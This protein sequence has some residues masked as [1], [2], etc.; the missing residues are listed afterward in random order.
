MNRNPRPPLWQ[1]LALLALVAMEMSAYTPW[2][3]AVSPPITA[4]PFARFFLLAAAV[5]LLTHGAYRLARF[6]RLRRNIRQALLVLV[7]ALAARAALSWWIDPRVEQNLLALYR[8]PLRGIGEAP[9]VIPA[10]FWTLLFVIGLWWRGLTLGRER[11]G[12]I[13]VMRSFKIGVLSLALF[14]PAE[15]LMRPEQPAAGLLLFFLFLSS[16]LLALVGSRVSTLARLR[17][18]HRNPFD[19]RWMAVVGT[20]AAAWA[21]LGLSAAALLS[22]RGAWL[23]ALFEALAVLFG[24]LIA[25]PFLLLLALLQPAFDALVQ[26]VPAAQGTPVPTPAA[27]ALPD[28]SAWQQPGG[29]AP[30]DVRPLFLTLGAV[31]LTLLVALALRMAAGRLERVPPRAA[32]D[33]LEGETLGGALRR[34]LEA[35]T[36]RLRGLGGTARRRR[37]AERIRQLYADFVDACARRGVARPPAATPL[38]FIPLTA[39]LLPAAQEEVRL[40]TE[41]YLRVRY[42]A[43]PETEEEVQAVERAWERLRAALRDAPAAGED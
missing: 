41:A 30:P 23:G 33:H 19:R 40:L 15:A 35:L 39:A 24:A 13:R 26:Q 11:V 4:T 10:W 3:H 34:R 17:G 42:G 9:R 18:G 1:E 37:A 38:E 27:P 31:A 16:A 12:P 36:G 25:A 21:A 5:V 2:M 28:F 6:L 29:W 43:L 14:T 7:L 20:T 8:Q 32:A 22:G